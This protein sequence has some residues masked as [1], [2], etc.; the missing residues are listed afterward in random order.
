[1]IRAS[2]PLT[3]V[4]LA[5]APAAAQQLHV[6]AYLLNVGVATASH[7]GRPGG[8]YDLQRAR[9]MATST[10]G[11]FSADLAYEQFVIVES[12]PPGLLAGALGQPVAQDWLPLQGSFVAGDHVAWRQRVDRLSLHYGTAQLALTIGRQPISWATTLLLTPAD[13]FA[14]FDPSDPFR[15]YRSGVD[16]ARVQLFP[17]PFSEVEAA[18]RVADTPEGTRLTG[19]L[20][21]RAD[22]GA[23]E[24][25]GWAGAVYGEAA[26]A[27]GVTWTVAGA[28]VRGE[29]ELR[30]LHDSTVVRGT[31]GVDRNFTVA[32]RALYLALEFQH[33]GF[34]AADAGQ[35][36]AVGAG[37]PARRGEL[38]VAGRNEVAGRI[39][40]QLHPL[41][42]LEWLSLFNFGDGSVLLAPAASYSAS[43]RLTVRSGLFVGAGAANGAAPVPGSEYGQVPPSWYLSASLFF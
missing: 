37:E 23:V 12:A 42:T 19:G 13:P 35:L 1:M 31:V 4:A 14:P 43:N 5:A 24:L 17:G 15:E 36:V 39:T 30:R 11:A 6:G 20:R 7:A 29:A 2:A 21:G 40:W 3:A 38:Q 27:A 8:V 16:A 9:L 25:S 34:G 41:V 32:G 33:D 18:V 10:L 28:A 26:A 22:A